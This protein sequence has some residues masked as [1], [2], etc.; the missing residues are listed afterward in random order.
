MR[1]KHWRILSRLFLLATWLVT[2]FHCPLER[3][4][5]FA[6]DNCCAEVSASP[7]AAP[8][9]GCSDDVCCNWASPAK[10]I[11]QRIVVA[12]PAVLVPVDF[13]V[14]TTPVPVDFLLTASPPELGSSW[15]FDQRAVLPARAPS[16]VS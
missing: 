14:E 7:D 11:D 1:V 4:G 13:L 12:I 6:A 2:T 8:S 3:A 9:K 10:G 15:Q 16:F 5:F